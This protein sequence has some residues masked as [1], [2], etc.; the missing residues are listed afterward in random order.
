MK[1][2]DWNQMSHMGLIEKINRE[3]LHPLGLAMTR[4]PATGKSDNVL[5]ADD[6]MWEYADDFK[7]RILPDDEVTRRIEQFSKDS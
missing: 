2:L 3:V 4:D 1:T 6:G 5:I 7:S